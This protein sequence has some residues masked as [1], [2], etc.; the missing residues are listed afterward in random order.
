MAVPLLHF[1]L[2]KLF[3]NVFR[4]LAIF[5]LAAVL[6]TFQNIG[7][8]FSKSSGHPAGDKHASLFCTTDKTYIG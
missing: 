5:S 1:H 7:R 6:A 8:L 4:I 2:N 3:K